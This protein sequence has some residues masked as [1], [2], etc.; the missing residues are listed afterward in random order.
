MNNRQL[1]ISTAATRTTLKWIKQSILWSEFVEKLRTPIRSPETLAAYLKL[2]K[3]Q[4]DNLKDVGGFIGGELI[5]NSRKKGV[6][7]RCFIALDLDNI[8]AGQTENILKRL[9][10]LNCAYVVYSTRKHSEDRPRLR[11]IIPLNRD[12]GPDEYEPIARKLASFIGMDL[13]DPTTFQ[14]SRLMYWSSCSSDSTYI[15]NYD[16]EKGFI[17]ADGMLRLYNN[18]QDVREWPQVPGSEKSIDILRKKQENPLEKKGIVGV[19]CR[20]YSITEAIEKFLPNTY[21]NCDVPDR[22]TYVGGSTTGGAIVYDDVFLYSHHATDPCSMKLCNAFDLVRLHKFGELDYDAKDGTPVITLPSYTAIKKL[23]LD[24]PKV[25]ESR[26]KEGI[27]SAIDDFGEEDGDN[28]WM[29][30]LSINIDSG[31]IEPTGENILIILE[32][33]PEIKGKLRYEEFSN[34]LRVL[35]PLPWNLSVDKR[36][37]KDIDD[38]QLRMFLEK[39]YKITGERKI[40]DAT[41]AC[42]DNNRF[43]ELQDYLKSLKWDRVERLESLLIKYLGAE[44]NIFTRE[45]IRKT[46]IAAVARAMGNFVKWDT[47]L[48]FSGPQGIGKSTFIRYLGRDWFSDSLQSFEGKEAYESLSGMWILEIGEL[49]ALNRSETNAA[50]QFLSKIEDSYRPA[51][52]RRLERHPRKC[53]FFATTNDK[54]F[55]KDATGNRRFWIIPVGINKPTKNIW[56]DLPNEV[57]QIWAEAYFYWQMGESLLLSAEAENLAKTAQKE[58]KSE[59][60]LE[61][62]ILEFLEK[63]ISEDWYTRDAK[64]RKNIML[65]NYTLPEEIKTVQRDRICPLEI[66][67]ECLNGSLTYKDP[68]TLKSIK[69]TLR[70][71]EDWEEVSPREFGKGYGC[72]RGFRRKLQNE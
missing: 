5:D 35:G 33:H 19:F 42:F 36:E 66:W 20:S 4:Q 17:D 48:T 45:S 65:G 25:Q 52:G 43:N 59:D 31:K 22:L 47:M 16:V 11:V 50:K 49:S 7:S 26:I 56:H 69:N 55:L 44:D 68:R 29:E 64:E 63:K 21:D 41:N 54:D 8:P 34:T 46:L 18:W 30:K 12:I 15:Y 67:T 27:N 28:T 53:I 32:N 24:D 37:W 13:C 2:P 51:Y 23:I 58:H 57:D 71:L 61:G 9:A 1:I 10:S 60:E 70:G 3:G 40:A 6:L 14:V 62:V 38:T 72:Q 39:K